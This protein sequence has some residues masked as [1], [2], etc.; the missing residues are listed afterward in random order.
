MTTVLCAVAVLPVARP[1]DATPG[2]TG[3]R[4]AAP[5]Q[6][7]S[8]SIPRLNVTSP[9]YSGATNAVYDRGV[10]HFPGT[11]LPGQWGNVVLGGHRTVNP[12]PFYDI[13]KL[14]KG[15]QILV[16]RAGRTYEYV[17]SKTMIVKP[18]SVW[19]LNQSAERSLTIFT[20]HPR[21]SARQRYVVMATLRP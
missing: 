2:L 10:G 15:D 12:R 11:A 20:C 9:I 21:G 6:L 18:T 17:V 16:T 8:I 4:G 1:V 3:A 5:R 14:V 7:G 13:Q 19:I